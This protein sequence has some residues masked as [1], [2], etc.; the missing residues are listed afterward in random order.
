MLMVHTGKAIEFARAE[1][2]QTVVRPEKAGR[3]W[4][5][6][7]HFDFAEG[8]TT[9]LAKRGCEIIEDRWATM[10]DNAALIGAIDL[11]LPD[12]EDIPGQRYSVGVAHGNDMSRSM[13]LTVGSRVMVC[14]NGVFTGEYVMR[15][16]HTTG[17]RLGYE[18]RNSVGRALTEFNETKN[19]IDRMKAQRM[20]SLEIDHAFVEVGRRGI[21]PW[22]AIGKAVE[23]HREPPHEEFVEFADRSW[24]VYQAVNHVIKQRSPISQMESLR[25]L[26]GLLAA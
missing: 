10:R 16:K 3:R 13:W 15:R 5:G 22:S 1:L 19:T 8:I 6:V 4:R 12:V 14:D 24:G 17:M 7:P 26:T 9:E 18:I 20:S 2:P 21:L 25:E 11:R 23:G